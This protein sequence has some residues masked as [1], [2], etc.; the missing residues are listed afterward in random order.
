MLCHGIADILMIQVGSQLGAAWVYW[1]A[2]ILVVYWQ[3]QQ[4]LR[5]ESRNRQACHAAFLD[6]NRI[7]WLWLAAIAAHFAFY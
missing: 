1:A 7:G 2:L 5:V 3:W 4:Y 6:N